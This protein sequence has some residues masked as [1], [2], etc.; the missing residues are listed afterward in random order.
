MASLKQQ[1]TALSTRV[2]RQDY[3]IDHLEGT[4]TSNLTEVMGML[5]TSAGSQGLPAESSHS[6]R[7]PE[8]QVSPL[9]AIAGSKLP[10]E[11]KRK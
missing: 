7:E 5:R 6:K 10:K 8:L 2:D 11:P 4:I 9:K 1:I 3:R